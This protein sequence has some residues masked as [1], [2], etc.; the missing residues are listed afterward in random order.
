MLCSAWT[1]AALQAGAVQSGHLARAAQRLKAACKHDRAQHLTRL[2]DAV[3][4]NDPGAPAAV[5]RLMGLKRKKPFQPEV[6]PELC[7]LDGSRCATPEEVASRWRQHFRMQ[8]DGV[9]VSPQDLATY[10]SSLPGGPTPAGAHELPSP[11]ILLQ[12]ITTALKNKAA[13]PDGIP[14]ELGHAAP[15]AL[16][17]LLMPLCLKVGLTCTEPAG[18][19]GSILAKLYKGR[20]EKTQCGSFRAIMLLSTFAKLLHK[21]FRPSLYDVFAAN[22]LPTQLGGRKST[23]VV[24]GAHLTRAFG[25]FC[26]SE[27]CTAI[28][29]FTD[30]A[31]AYYTA[32]R[33]LTAV[34]GDPEADPRANGTASDSL[35][36]VELAQPTALQQASASPWV[37]ALTAEFNSHTWM[38]T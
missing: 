18:F 24:L 3:E 35:L 27:G 12:A 38:Y 31:S 37:E 17:P 20:G 29:L 32:V 25:R 5:A 21:S 28:T 4:R 30:V 36:A 14:S 10:A 1:R 16:L 2:A 23:S 7:Q 19:K 34:R 33:A 6:L 9:E 8:E 26:A 15:H 13:G 11:G 22:A